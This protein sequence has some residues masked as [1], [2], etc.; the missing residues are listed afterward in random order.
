[1]VQKIALLSEEVIN[2]I[3]AGEVVENPASIAKEL[4]ENS[5]DA[6]ALC[7]DISIEGGGCRLLQIEDDGCGMG[8]ED[9]LL[10]LERHATSKIRS[11]QD[12][13]SLATMGFRGEALAAV[14]SVSLFEMRTSDGV[15]GTQ[16]EIKGGERG[17]PLPCA[18][19]RGDYS[20]CA[21][22]FFQRS[23]PEKILKIDICKYIRFDAD[24]RN[25]R[26]CSSGGL[27]HF[28]NGWENGFTAF[29]G[30]NKEADQNHRGSDA[31]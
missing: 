26:S 11:E 1:M 21:R 30:R 27:I 28:E 15:S 10:S 9:A 4:I 5:L 18:R 3:A 6:G 17:V 19:N 23:C 29:P 2:K 8:P 12:L 14:S 24:R 22:P 13:F 31:S 16:I 25:Y 7:L 20:N